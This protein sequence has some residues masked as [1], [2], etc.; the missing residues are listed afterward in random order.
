MDEIYG[1]KPNQALVR[2]FHIVDAM[3]LGGTDIRGLHYT[4]R[5][6]KTHELIILR[7][8]FNC[9]C[10]SKRFLDNNLQA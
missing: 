2:T 5:Y 4:A 3:V 7:N 8:K 6:I 9:T 10:E 1:K